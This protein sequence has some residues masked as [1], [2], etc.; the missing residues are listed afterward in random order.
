MECISLIFDCL[1]KICD[2]G[3]C[4][5]GCCDEYDDINEQ[6][7]ETKHNKQGYKQPSKCSFFNNNIQYKTFDEDFQ[8]P[9]II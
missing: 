9:N 3:C 8:S 5:C 4:E 1:F 6:S 7:H 2:F